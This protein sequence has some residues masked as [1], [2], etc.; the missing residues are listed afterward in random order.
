MLERQLPIV[1]M[2]FLDHKYGT[3]ATQMTSQCVLS[4]PPLR[5]GRAPSAVGKSL[6]PAPAKP[7]PSSIEALSRLQRSHFW[8]LDLRIFIY[9][10]PKDLRIFIYFHPKY[11]RIF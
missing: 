4:K 7:L 3:Y 2:L 8:T 10:R 1:S 5:S 9:F 6:F 11:L